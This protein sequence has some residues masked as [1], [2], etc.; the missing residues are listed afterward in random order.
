MNTKRMTN[1]GPLTPTRLLFSSGGP[2]LAYGH[3]CSCFLL[4]RAS[5][6][7]PGHITKLHVPLALQLEPYD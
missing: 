2:S 7:G 3:Q 5:G 1:L 6:L 4:R